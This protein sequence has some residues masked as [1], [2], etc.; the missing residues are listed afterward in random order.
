MLCTLLVFFASQSTKHKAQSSTKK[1]EAGDPRYRLPLL[2]L[3]H[4]LRGGASEGGSIDLLL[5]FSNDSCNAV[6]GF[7]EERFS[8]KILPGAASAVNCGET[9]KRL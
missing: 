7:F 1:S 9:T 6:A 2:N 5:I 4:L 8:P 3:S